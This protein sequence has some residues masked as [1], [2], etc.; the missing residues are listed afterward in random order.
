MIIGDRLIA[1]EPKRYSP[2][3]KMTNINEEILIEKMA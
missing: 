1:F 3:D 2:L